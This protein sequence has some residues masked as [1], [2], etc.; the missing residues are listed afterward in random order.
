MEDS[1]HLALALVHDT[2]RH[3]KEAIKQFIKSSTQSHTPTPVLVIT[4][5]LKP[6][7][8]IEYLRSGAADCV[9]GPVEQERMRF[10]I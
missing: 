9:S 3:D 4:D 10:S 8:M 6:E 1:H 2:G 7:V 5:L